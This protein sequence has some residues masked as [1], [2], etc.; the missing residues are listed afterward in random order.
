MTLY[1]LTLLVLLTIVKQELERDF[2]VPF[3]I[4]L[5]IGRDRNCPPQ[6]ILR[7]FAFKSR[8]LIDTSSIGVINYKNTMVKYFLTNGIWRQGFID[9]KLLWLNKLL[10]LRI[11]NLK[12]RRL[13]NTSTIGELYKKIF[14]HNC[15]IFLTNC[16]WYMVQTKS[17]FIRVSKATVVKLNVNFTDIY[18]Q[19]KKIDQHNNMGVI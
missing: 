1:I 8:I 12:S 7:I 17:L 19:I 6:L 14:S 9:Q 10:I 13:I 3:Q 2:K 15:L 16:S 4:L 5:C 11:F 18:F